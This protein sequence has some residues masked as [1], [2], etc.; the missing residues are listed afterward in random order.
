MSARKMLDGKEVPTGYKVPRYVPFV[1]EW[2][3]STSKIQK[4]RLRDQI[5]TELGISED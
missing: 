1:T 3:M 2:P 5:M 4:F